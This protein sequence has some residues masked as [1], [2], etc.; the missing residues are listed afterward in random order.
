MKNRFSTNGDYEQRLI[1][2]AKAGNKKAFGELYRKYNLLIYRYILSNTGTPQ[3][4]EDLTT[5]VFIKAWNALDTYE[6]IGYSYGAFLL[7]IA[8]NITIDYHRAQ[9]GE[10]PIDDEIIENTSPNGKSPAESLTLRNETKALSQALRKL[11]DDYLQVLSLRFFSDIDIEQAAEILS[12]SEGAVRVLQHRALKTLRNILEE[13][14]Q[15]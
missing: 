15:T 10:K 8:K 6:D 3:D 11:P 1:K 4:A 9:K 2:R 14:D 7:K 12:R 5:D 13:E